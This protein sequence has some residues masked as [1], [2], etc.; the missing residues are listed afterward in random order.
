MN[1]DL[2]RIKISDEGGVPVARVTGEIDTSNAENV[3]RVLL[4]AVSNQAA[5][6][7][8]DLTHTTYLDSSGVHILFAAAERLEARQLALRVVVPSD[9][10]ILDVFKVT[11]L[12]A[13]VPVD[14]TVEAAVDAL[15]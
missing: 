11:G 12:A 14:E 8:V 7:I 6:L 15:K 9:S 5:G 3:L 2:A 13:A 4:G 10:M 1:G